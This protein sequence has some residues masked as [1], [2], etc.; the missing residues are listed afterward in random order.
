M[1][2]DIG[3]GSCFKNNWKLT[4]EMALVSKIIESWHWKWFVFQKQLKLVKNDSCFKT[5]WKLTLEMV[6]VS[7]MILKIVLVSKI[8]QTDTGNGFCFKNN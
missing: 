5:N 8:V 4:L 6:L 1:K 2:V 3:N 7:K